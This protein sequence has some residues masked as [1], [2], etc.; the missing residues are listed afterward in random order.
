MHVQHDHELDH[1]G[2]AFEPAERVIRLRFAGHSSGRS[3]SSARIEEPRTV[4]RATVVMPRIMI[5]CPTAN[6]PVATGYR[7]A[8]LNLQSDATTRSFRC[9][10][11]SI[12]VWRPDVAWME[13]RDLH[14]EM[15]AEMR[16]FGTVHQQPASPGPRMKSAAEL[17]HRAARAARKRRDALTEPW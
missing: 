6:E 8:D 16:A 1:L 9:P 14:E 17:Q 7:N 3:R 2:R 15:A 4:R 11:G 13:S 5:V 12:H 10:C